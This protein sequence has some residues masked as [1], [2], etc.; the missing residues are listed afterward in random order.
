MNEVFSKY[1]TH[2]RTATEV[3]LDLLGNFPSVTP[4]EKWRQLHRN[5]LNSENPTDIQYKWLRA[6]ADVESY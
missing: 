5:K 4:H 2:P 3:Q 1:L 6:V